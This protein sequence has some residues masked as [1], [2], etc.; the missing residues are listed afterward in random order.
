M[1]EWFNLMF[2]KPHLF[3]SGHHGIPVTRH[4]FRYM[5]RGQSTGRSRVIPSLGHEG[6]VDSCLP[7]DMNG[8]LI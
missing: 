2:P 3:S 4:L 5:I 1:G 8:K 7:K 6:E